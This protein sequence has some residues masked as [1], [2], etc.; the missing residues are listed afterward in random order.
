MKW[1]HTKIKKFWR[2]CCRDIIFSCQN[3]GKRMKIEILSLTKLSKL[4]LKCK[5]RMEYDKL[6]KIL[7]RSLNNPTKSS[8]WAHMTSMACKY[9]CMCV[10]VSKWLPDMTCNIWICVTIYGNNIIIN[11]HL[12]AY[13]SL[14]YVCM[15]VYM[16]TLRL[17]L[18]GDVSYVSRCRGVTA[19]CNDEWR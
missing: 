3:S 8:I 6:V 11:R 18:G 9:V 10:R 1:L 15:Y 7:K 4:S 16:S 2:N 13:E 14:E 12:N 19:H 17:Q 5:F